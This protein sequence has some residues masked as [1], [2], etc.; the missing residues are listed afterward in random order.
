MVSTSVMS[1][2]TTLMTTMT[3]KKKPAVKKKAAKKPS[4]LQ[5]QRKLENT[6]RENFAMCYAAN[7]GNATQAYREAKYPGKGARQS[8]HKLLTIP[9]VKQRVLYYQRLFHEKLMATKEDTLRHVSE[10]AMFDPVNMFDE[11]GKLLPITEMD[12]AT[13]KSITE[14]KMVGGD[15]LITEVKYGKDT[16]AYTDMLMKHYNQYEAHQKDGA[17]KELKV[18]LLYPNDALA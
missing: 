3:T 15:E 7:G 1:V 13:R 11:D 18:Y 4:P 17:N 2:D 6:R 9:D 16:R 8:A 12:A 5:R 10:M 14:I